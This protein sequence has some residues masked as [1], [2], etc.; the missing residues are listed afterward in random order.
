MHNLIVSSRTAVSC[1]FQQHRTNYP[2]ES[3]WLL[4]KARHHKRHQQ[5]K[6][7]SF[8]PRDAMLARYMLSSCVRLSICLSVTSRY[9]V[10]TAKIR[11]TQ[12]RPHDSL[13]SLVFWCQRSPRNSTGITPYGGANCRWCGLK[14]ATFDK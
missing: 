8:L 14:S 5:F 13:G 2:A 4:V 12:T 7:T 11:I 10:K 3:Y 9:C 6:V 1:G